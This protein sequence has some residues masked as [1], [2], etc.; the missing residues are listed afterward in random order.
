VTRPKL[1]KEPPASRYDEGAA[2]RAYA[3]S[4]LTDP[5]SSPEDIERAQARLMTPVMSIEE[6][7]ASVARNLTPAQRA[8]I[9]SIELE[10]D[11]EI[12][13]ED[14]GK[15]EPGP[16][17]LRARRQL[18][19]ERLIDAERDRLAIAELLAGLDEQLAAEAGRPTPPLEVV[20][21]ADPDEAV[22]SLVIATEPIAAP[23]TATDWVAEAKRILAERDKREAERLAAEQVKLD[24]RR[25]REQQRA[26]RE[27]EREE[28]RR[29]GY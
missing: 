15:A 25:T 7:A 6:R 20:L 1:P 18:A 2:L 5:T 12:V 9:A 3:M 19:W 22:E 4:I 10:D 27:Q 28:R 13:G 26:A 17:D 8:V 14:G 16:T 11:V 21:T 23:K 29:R 24:E